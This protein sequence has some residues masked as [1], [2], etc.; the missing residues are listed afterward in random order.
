MDINDELTTAEWRKASKSGANGGDCIEVAPLSQGRVG[1]RDSEH[2][3]SPAYVVS[4]GVWAAF[5]DGVK[6]GE[7][8]F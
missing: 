8:D 4:A 7:F 2:P 6:K 3:E 1:I 5:T